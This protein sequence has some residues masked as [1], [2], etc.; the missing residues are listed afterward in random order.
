LEKLPTL[1]TP[2]QESNNRLDRY[3][4]NPVGTT[5]F[6]GVIVE[7]NVRLEHASNKPF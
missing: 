5:Q 6:V 3:R 1:V 7:G 4:L 2:G